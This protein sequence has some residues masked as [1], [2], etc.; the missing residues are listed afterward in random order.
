MKKNY[1]VE[2]S[3]R[4]LIAQFKFDS[5]GEASEFME[6]AADH[7]VEP[8]DKGDMVT[9]VMKLEIEDEDA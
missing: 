2:L 1:I 3:Q 6:T 9:V 4:W 8:E 7:L 5:A